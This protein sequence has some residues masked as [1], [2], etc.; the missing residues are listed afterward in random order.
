MA[1]QPAEVDDGAMTSSTSR[2]STRRTA[3]RRAAARRSW[4]VLGSALSLVLVAAT[5]CNRY[6]DEIDGSGTPETIDV[7]TGDGFNQLELNHGFEVDVVVAEGPTSIEVT[8]DDNLVDYLDVEVRGDVLQVGFQQR[9][10]YDFDVQPTATISMP[11]LERIDLGG[12][13]TANVAGVEAEEAIDVD[14]SGASDL[15][16]NARVDSLTIDASGA[17]NVDVDGRAED[18]QIDASGASNVDLG[19]LDASGATVDLSGAS[20]LRLGTVE[21]VEGALSGASTL[22]AA[23]TSDVNV[24]TS[25]ASSVAW[26]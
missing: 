14:A 23:S 17:S 24:R 8:V 25:G 11:S 7:A 16:L 12:A 15:S 26:R 9:V 2:T 19:S 21:R 13:V 6:L 3:T 18:V 4:L 1:G 5:G 20:F 10:S 22:A